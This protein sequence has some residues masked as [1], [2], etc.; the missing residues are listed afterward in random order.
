VSY[1][2]NRALPLLCLGDLTDSDRP[3]ACTVEVLASEMAYM[4]ADQI[5]VWYILVN[6]RHAWVVRANTVNRWPSFFGKGCM[7]QLTIAS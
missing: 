6:Q 5:S 2:V 4:Q 7:S 1:C 3:V